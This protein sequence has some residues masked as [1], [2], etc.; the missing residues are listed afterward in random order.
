MSA[1]PFGSM[2]GTDPVERFEAQLVAT[3]R[4]LPY[5]PTPDLAAAFR[6]APG[7]TPRVQVVARR[8]P[9]LSARARWAAAAMAAVLIL[10]LGLLAVPAV[11]AGVIEFLRIGAVR[12]NLVASPTPTPAPTPTGTPPPTPLPS[13]TPLASVLNLDGQTTLEDARARAGFT[14]GLPT[15][16][17]DLGQ[18]DEVFLQDL[19]GTA[20]VLVW[21]KPEQRDQV[22]LSLHILSSSMLVDK[23]LKQSPQG[24]EFTHVNDHEAV[25]TT[26]PYLVVARNGNYT[27]TRL[28]T[29]HVL[30]WTAGSLTYRLEADLPLDEAV[31]IAESIQ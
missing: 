22:R 4:A 30:I 15:Y 8:R 18:P 3:A 11:R 27:Q 20:V 2:N 23:M 21:R 14:I 31:R 25:W 10:A 9:P 29:G 28:V 12:I 24:I 26:G 19:E 1:S 7:L 5:P 13:A 17:A 16:P 6:A